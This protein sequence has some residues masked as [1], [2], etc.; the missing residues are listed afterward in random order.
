MADRTVTV[1]SSGGT[2]LSL[3]AAYAGEDGYDCVTN[4]G[5]LIIECYNF[6]DT[7]PVNSLDVSGIVTSATYK[8]IVRAMDSAAQPLSLSAYHLHVSGSNR[9]FRE[10]NNIEYM[11]FEN[12]QFWYEGVSGS[13]AGFRQDSGATG[14]EWNFKDCVF[15]FEY[16]D[17]EVWTGG[18]FRFT[19][20]DV[21]M[22]FQNCIVYGD[23]VATSSIGIWADGS[24]I[25]IWFDGGIIDGFTNAFKLD[26]LG[27]RVRNTKIT[28]CTNII[29]VGGVQ[30]DFHSDSD[31]NLTDLNTVPTNWGANSI[32]GTDTPTIDYTDPSN[33]TYESRDFHTDSDSDSG[34]GAGT[35]LSGDGDNPYS[36]DFDGNTRVAWD[37]GAFEYQSAAGTGG[38][39]AVAKTIATFAAI[40]RASTW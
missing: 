16:G 2:Y 5:D 37:I 28:N 8:I 29:D 3:N 11:D 35:N 18:G 26:S 7:V 39:K 32:D 17:A 12:V 25:D 23:G 10:Q 15:C 31:Y 21:A 34:V 19:D 9:L 22:K 13:L 20:N 38:S 24:G 4:A 6:E 30:S 36:N 1:K 33:A 27:V 40:Q 14:G